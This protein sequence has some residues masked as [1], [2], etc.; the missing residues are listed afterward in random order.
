MTS[1]Q[2]SHFDARPTSPFSDSPEG[3]TKINV[4]GTTCLLDLSAGQLDTAS[5]ER[6]A[7]DKEG[8]WEATSERQRFQ[9][10]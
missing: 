10:Q 7:A 2:G 8:T 5:A 9:C 3:P 1:I 6:V 4:T